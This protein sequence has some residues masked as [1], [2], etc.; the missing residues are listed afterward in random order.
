M[1]ELKGETTVFYSTHILDD[2][3][4]VSDPSRSSTTAASS[5]PPRPRPCWARS[6]WLVSMVVLVIGPKLVFDR[7]EF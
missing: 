4:R 2:V 7:Q 6:R 3:Q 1:Q 5:R